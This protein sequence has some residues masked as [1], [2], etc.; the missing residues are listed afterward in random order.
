MNIDKLNNLYSSKKAEQ[1]LLKSQLNTAKI[2]Y[3]E[4][5]KNHLASIQVREYFKD[6]AQKTQGKLESYVSSL[7]TMAL[8]EIFPDPYEFKARFTSRRN[9]TE[10]DLLFL[11]DGEEYI[12]KESS[13]GGPLDVVSTILKVAFWSL[14]KNRPVFILDE[15]GKYISVDLQDKFSYMIKTIAVKLK[16]QFIIISHQEAMIAAADK[17]F[18]VSRGK[19]KE[20]KL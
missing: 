8:Q 2:K 1:K 13:G 17:A 19:V 14:K 10:C 3:K 15:P 7:V 12:P 6:I 20:I 5:N 4:A 16:L 18:Q 11:K 9:K